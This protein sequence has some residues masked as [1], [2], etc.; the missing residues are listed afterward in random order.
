MYL[1]LFRNVHYCLQVDG[2]CCKFTCVELPDLPDQGEDGVNKT[3]AVL[4]GYTDTGTNYL[5]AY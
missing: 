2:E 3:V 5:T 1:N 4:P